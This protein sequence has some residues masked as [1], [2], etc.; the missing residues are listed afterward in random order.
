[1]AL[2]TARSRP[3][4]QDVLKNRCDFQTLKAGIKKVAT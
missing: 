3:T 1:M 2:R 4:H